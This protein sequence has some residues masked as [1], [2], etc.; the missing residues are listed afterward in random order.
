MIAHLVPPLVEHIKHR[1]PKVRY[2]A[3]HVIGQFADDMAVKFQEVFHDQVFPALVAALD[4]P[5]PRVAAHACAALTNFCEY[6]NPTVL[7]PHVKGVCE[8]LCHLIQNGVIFV[9]ENA[10]TCLS[11]IADRIETKFENYFK[12]TLTFLITYLN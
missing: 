9:K 7:M 3:L 6:A 1:N 11:E 2:A 5:V 4:D 12:T 10:V 8:K